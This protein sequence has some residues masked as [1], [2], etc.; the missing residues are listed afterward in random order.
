MPP[1]KSSK[2][3]IRYTES[4]NRRNNITEI[5]NISI[6]IISKI[7]LSRLRGLWREILSFI[8]DSISCCFKLL[9]LLLFPICL[10][11]YPFNLLWV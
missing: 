4:L 2:A 10:P 3:R 7:F 8:S 11:Y 9:M 6:T 1:I 5:K